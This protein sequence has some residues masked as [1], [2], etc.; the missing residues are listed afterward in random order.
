MTRKT[1]T[2]G[3]LAELHGARWHQVYQAIRRLGL[4]PA[5][6]VG[7]TRVYGVEARDRIGKW[8]EEHARRK[9]GVV[10]PGNGPGNGETAAD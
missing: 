10:A 6:V 1:Y 3:G 5:E 7:G 4:E 8:L 2:I 9:L